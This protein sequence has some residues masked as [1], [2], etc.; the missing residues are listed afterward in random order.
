MA[1]QKVSFPESN[2]L[3]VGVQIVGVQ[4]VGARIVGAQRQGRP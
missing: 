1:S 2:H 4:I 3:L